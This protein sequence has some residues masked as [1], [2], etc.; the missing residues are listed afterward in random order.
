M[1]LRINQLARIEGH[2]DLVVDLEKGELVSCR[3]EVVETPRFFEGILT[4][5]HYREVAGVVSRICGICSHSHSLVSLTATEDALGI[6]ISD[7]TRLL[8]ELLLC[9]ELLQSHLVQLYFMALPDYLR[10]PSLIQAAKSDRTL[11]ERALR[12]KKGANAICE[13][14]GGRPVHPVTLRV[15]G[16]A[17]LPERKELLQLQQHLRNLLPD[18]EETIDLFAGLDIPLFSRPV[19]NV[20]LQGDGGYPVFGTHMESSDGAVLPVAGYVGQINE[21]LVAHATAKHA[22]MEGH[23]YRV[24]SL[25]RLNN[26]HQ[27][28]APM[29]AKVAAVLR[30][31][32]GEENPYR[33]LLAR[34]VE[35]VHFVERGIQLI[36]RL[37]DYDL[38]PEEPP[39]PRRFGS[40]VAA[41]EAPRGLLLH[42]YR[43]GEEGR[44]LEADC[45]IPTAQN[46]AS[47]EEDLAG[48]VP[49]I[50][51]LEPDEVSRQL[52]MLIR[53]YDP[54]I[55]CA[56][57]LLRVK[58]V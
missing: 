46:L 56:T 23:R 25:A 36:D 49:E 41:V 29:A 57:H 6:D 8:R 33:M 42:A 11:L 4:G 1:Q 2:A 55:S 27:G 48:R 38:A 7:Q 40:G 37:E 5:L 35:V 45:V 24:G 21:R 22:E 51:H 20:S 16:F 47:L 39:L 34:L 52:E 31:G 43:Y 15:G 13:V 44:L 14:I 17:S 32:P 9:G 26:H 18:L 28:L 19:S 30:I 10:L 12:L 3:F 53:A 58:Y 50:A 54:C